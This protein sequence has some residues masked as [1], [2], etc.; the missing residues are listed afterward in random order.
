MTPTLKI[1][2]IAFILIFF[3]NSSRSQSNDRQNQSQGVN[4]SVSADSL[5]NQINRI[6]QTI[7]DSSY[8]RIPNKDFETIIDNKIEKSLQETIKWY[9]IIISAIASLLSFL[10]L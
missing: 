8:T 2:I 5:K 4:S 9:L 1:I 3:S 7:A 6:Q 10:I